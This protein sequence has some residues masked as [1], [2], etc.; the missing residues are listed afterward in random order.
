MWAEAILS[1]EDLA[2]VVQDFTPVKIRLGEEGELSLYDASEVTL[3]PDSGLRIACKAELKWPLLGITLPVKLNS[4]IVLVTPVIEKRAD[5]DALVFRLLVEH[6]DLTMVPTVIDNQITDRVNRALAEKHIELSW[7]FSETLSH[8]FQLPAALENLASFGLKVAWGEVKVG[9]DALV[10]AVSFH[11][12]IRRRSQNASASG[13]TA[14]V[15]NAEPTPPPDMHEP[16]ARV[17][18]L[19]LVRRSDVRFMTV[20]PK[21]VAIGAAI[22]MLTAG[23]GYALGR[24]FGRR[25][26]MRLLR[27][28]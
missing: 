12:E 23:I 14:E 16:S 21:A 22:A 1:K 24:A 28:R 5:G 6:A 18:R 25:P 13:A 26:T 27:S 4:L 20:P 8:V 9:A 2:K 7:K 15:P 3:V 10:L 19:A 17:E 11:S